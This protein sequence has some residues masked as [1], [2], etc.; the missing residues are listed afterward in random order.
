MKQRTKRTFSVSHS[1]AMGLMSWIFKDQNIQDSEWTRE[2]PGS[3]YW[4]YAENVSLWISVGVHRVQGQVAY[5]GHHSSEPGQ[6]GYV[7]TRA[8]CTCCVCIKYVSVYM[9]YI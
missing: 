3:Q 5:W 1:T 8:V 6:E 4:G 9:M 2:T 7:C